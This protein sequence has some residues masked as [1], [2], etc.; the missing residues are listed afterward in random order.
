MNLECIYNKE[1]CFTKF[2]AKRELEFEHKEKVDA[3]SAKQM[4]ESKVSRLRLGFSRYDDTSK[5]VGCFCV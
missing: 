1:K 3:L 4:E 5:S 2:P